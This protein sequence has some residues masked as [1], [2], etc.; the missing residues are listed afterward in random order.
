MSKLCLILRRVHGE[1]ME[2]VVECILGNDFGTIDYAF[3]KPPRGGDSGGGTPPQQTCFSGQKPFPDPPCNSRVG[4]REGKKGRE[5]E[6]GR[7][8]GKKRRAEG[9]RTKSREGK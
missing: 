2:G 9:G 8:E 3:A 7:R 5:E 4:R 6:K 1:D